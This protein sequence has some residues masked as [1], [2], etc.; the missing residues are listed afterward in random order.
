MSGKTYTKTA[1]EFLAFVQVTPTHIPLTRNGEPIVF[2]EFV[3]DLDE[4]AG[5]YVDRRVARLN[6]GIPNPKVRPVVKLPWELE[7]DLH[8]LEE[9]DVR[10]VTLKGYIARGGLALGLG[11][12]RGVFGKF[13]MD[14]WK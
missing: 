12:Y 7:F 5:I 1:N 9:G 8:I 3:G 10:E 13:E 14:M 11:T 4:K 6:K 2:N